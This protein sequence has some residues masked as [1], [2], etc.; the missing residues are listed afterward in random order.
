[1]VSAHLTGPIANCGIIKLYYYYYYYYYS[2]G[3]ASQPGYNTLRD[4]LFILYKRNIQ[5]IVYI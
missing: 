4:Y 5:T 2:G 1:M 3:A